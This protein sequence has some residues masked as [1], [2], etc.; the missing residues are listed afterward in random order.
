VN[1]DRYTVK[2]YRRG[3]RRGWL[4][5]VLRLPPRS[6]LVF[7]GPVQSV[8]IERSRGGDRCTIEIGDALAA[9]LE[10]SGNG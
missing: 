6:H 5:K 8:T 10:V 3:Q 9:L 2:V 1:V 4:R 7:C